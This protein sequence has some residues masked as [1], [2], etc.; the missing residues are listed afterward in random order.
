MVGKLVLNQKSD[1]IWALDAGHGIDTPGKRSPVWKDGTQLFEWEY[2]RKIR[3]TIIQLLD[4]YNMSYFIVNPEDYDI[5]LTERANRINKIGR[6]TGKK[7]ITVSIHGN[8]AGVESASG[9][10]VY[11]SEGQT[12]SDPIA[13]VFYKHAKMSSLFRMRQ[14]TTDGDNDKEAR[15][16][17]LTKTV[18]PALLTESGFYT[19]ELECR[20]ML[21]L[22]FVN[23]LGLMHFTAMLEIEA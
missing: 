13:E 18:G 8:A 19:N 6:D 17:I 21:T 16:T 12:S 15:F 5:G 2:V 20:K 1:I 14:D 3:N 11:T 7:V 22:D 10:E 4:L 23:Q 9:Y